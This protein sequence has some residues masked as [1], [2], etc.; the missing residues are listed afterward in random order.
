MLNRLLLLIFIV[1]SF[2]SL[3]CTCPPSLLNLEECKKYELIF[4]GKVKD[5]K[6]CELKPG[7]ATFEVLE[8]YKGNATPEF[9]VLFTCKDPCARQFKPGEEWI[10]YTRYKQ[11]ENAEMDW[12]SRS[13]KHFTTDKEDYYLVLYGNDY[14]D[15]LKFLR[16]ELGLHRLLVK[17]E[18][19]QNRNTRPDTFQ[20]AIIL[21][22]SLGALILFYYLFNRFF[23]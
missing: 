19:S 14:E 7:E 20:S 9:N 11:I 18:V 2:P 17:K 16:K 15:E 12:C 4:R 8:L 1:S 10:I 6:T 22:V 5:V 3:A 23:R 21:I 13:R